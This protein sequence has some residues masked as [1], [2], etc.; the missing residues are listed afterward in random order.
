MCM[1]SFYHFEPCQS[2]EIK[3]EI[4][5]THR[6][7]RTL[8][9]LRSKVVASSKLVSL[10]MQNASNDFLFTC[11]SSTLLRNGNHKKN[12][13]FLVKHYSTGSHMD[14]TKIQF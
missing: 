7:N 13:D 14:M 9:W 10:F 11:H 3:R 12:D 1:L 5:S 4:Y 6:R 2:I 8:L